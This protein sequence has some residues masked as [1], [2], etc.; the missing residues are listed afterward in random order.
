MFLCRE[1]LFFLLVY[2]FFILEFLSESL[3]CSDVLNLKYPIRWK[4]FV[5][6]GD[7]YYFYVTVF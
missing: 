7:Y 1:I 2:G 3:F 5:V 4:S 6:S